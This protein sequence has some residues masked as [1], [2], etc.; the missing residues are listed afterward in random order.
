M[1]LPPAA[2]AARQAAERSQRTRNLGVAG[3]IGSFVLGVFFYTIQNVDQD[4]ITERDLEAFRKQRER[5]RAR[6]A[7]QR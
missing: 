1:A 3:L 6:D 2:E 5:Q 7:Q 4:T